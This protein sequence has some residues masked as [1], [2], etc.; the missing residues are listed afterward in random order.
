MGKP[1]DVI[2]ERLNND[3]VVV[4]VYEVVVKIMV[5]IEVQLLF[6]V[7]GWSDKTRLI[8]IST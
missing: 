7:G 6:R 3:D 8:L 5:E 1:A 2:L 4:V